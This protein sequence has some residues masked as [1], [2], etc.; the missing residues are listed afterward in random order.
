MKYSLPVILMLMSLTSSAYAVRMNSIYT[1]QIPVSTQSAQDRAQQVSSALAQVFVKVTGNSQTLNN[2][3][4]KTS[5]NSADSLL[6]AFSY[7]VSTDSMKPYLLEIQFDSEGVNKLLQKAAVPIWGSNRPLILGWIEYE[8]PNHAT[9]IIESS[10]NQTIQSILKSQA[11]LRGLPFILPTMDITDLSQITINDIVVM[12]IP[13]LQEAS[14]RYNAD[15]LLIARIF[16]LTT[17]CSARAKLVIGADQWDWTITG[18]TQLE[19]VNALMD[20][21]ADKLASRYATIVT[22]AVQDKFSLKVMGIAQKNAFENMLH[23]V[24][25]LT[26]VANVEVSQIEGDNVTLNVSLRGSKE[27]FVKALSLGNKLT[28]VD[29]KDNKLTYQWNR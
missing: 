7:G 27:A 25:R 19:V 28:S 10:S 11:D 22:N 5:L 13:K 2:P 15:A 1:G 21:I 12:T 16:Q 8:T 18:K 4:L 9:E 29:V 6:Q 20:K 17:G 26:S 24:Q 14:K 3:T 23:Y